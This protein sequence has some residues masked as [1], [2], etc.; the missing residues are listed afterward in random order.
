MADLVGQQL[1]SYRLV[2]LIGEGGFAEV[3][4]G[5]HLHLG[6]FAALKVLSKSLKSVDLERFRLEAQTIARLKHPHIVQVLEFGVT[7]DIPFLVMEFAPHGT[8]R[9]RH[10]KGT[11]L[12]L[13]TIV[14][15]IQQVADALQYAHGNGIIHRDLKPENLLLGAQDELLLSDFGMALVA[16]SSQY[17]A[18]EEIV[19]TAAYMAPEQIQTHPV[20]Q[21]DQYALGVMIYEWISGSPPFQ[22]SISE[23]IAKHL[24]VAPPSLQHHIP[25]LSPMVE[26]VVLTALAKDPKARFDSI[27]ALA[28][29][30][31]QAS[32]MQ[33]ST[34][35]SPIPSLPPPLAAA[36]S[37]VTAPPGQAAPA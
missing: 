3:Y 1:G 28:T 30:L 17:Q 16:Q 35:V 27:Q 11:R 31:E 6:I 29:A 20:P 18:T 14:P 4:L 19:G 5:E 21:S 23:V 2:R 34:L 36:A 22:G 13:S 37:P 33:Q 25:A 32:R 24:F 7:D 9:T 8:L 26:E 15:Y 12:S 10:P